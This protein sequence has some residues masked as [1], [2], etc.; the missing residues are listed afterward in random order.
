MFAQLVLSLL[1]LRWQLEISGAW[2]PATLTVPSEYSQALVLTAPMAEAHI[3]LQPSDS[4]TLAHQPEC[5]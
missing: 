4:Q 2:G 5:S 1:L 3:K